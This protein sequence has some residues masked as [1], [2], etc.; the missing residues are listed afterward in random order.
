MLN[1]SGIS[2]SISLRISA[3]VQVTQIAIESC[4]KGFFFQNYPDPL[5]NK[6]FAM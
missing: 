2:I 1:L 3:K 4:S 5:E 6:N